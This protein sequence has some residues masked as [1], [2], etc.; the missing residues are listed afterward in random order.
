M[1]FIVSAAVLIFV[2]AS[3]QMHRDHPYGGITVLQAQES[4]GGVQ[5][6][7]CCNKKNG[8]GNNGGALSSLLGNGLLVECEKL[9][10]ASRKTGYFLNG[11]PT[12]E[13]VL[14]RDTTAQSIHFCRFDCLL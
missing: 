7:V 5:T 4:W 10:V 11:Y 6:F 14:V 12:V 3:P 9:D 2:V 8:N 13:Q 1:H